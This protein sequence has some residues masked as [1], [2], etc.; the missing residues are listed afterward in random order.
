M[1][2][3][4]LHTSHL[5]VFLLLFLTE[6]LQSIPSEFEFVVRLGQ[7]DGLEHSLAQAAEF[8][9]LRLPRHGELL[10]LTLRLEL[11]RGVRAKVRE[12]Y[13]ALAMGRED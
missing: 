10:T 8:R 11:R 6:R 2:L 9:A 12:G 5:A 3:R 4:Q 13:D 7:R 1:R